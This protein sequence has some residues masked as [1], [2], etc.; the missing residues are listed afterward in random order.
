M[1]HFALASGPWNIFFTETEVIRKKWQCHWGQT[2]G[3]GTGHRT[4][5]LIQLWSK[6][7][8]ADSA[9]F[10]VAPENKK[11]IFNRFNQRLVQLTRWLRGHCLLTQVTQRVAVTALCLN[12]TLSQLKHHTQHLSCELSL[13]ALE[14]FHIENN[15]WNW[16]Q[17]IGHRADC[18]HSTLKGGPK[19]ETFLSWRSSD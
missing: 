16:G 6:E 14:L 1:N 15:K 10:R 12:P 11:L 18:W 2:K 13:L 17:G 9:H 4:R 19:E 8:V 7:P 5:L 3:Q